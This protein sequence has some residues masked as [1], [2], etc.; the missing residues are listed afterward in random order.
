MY[1]IIIDTDVLTDIQHAVDWYN[2]QK[3]GLGEEFFFAFEKETQLLKQSPYIC[4]IKYDYIRCK[5]IR[6]Y[7]F[8]IHYSISEQFQTIIIAGVFHTSR[9]PKIWKQKN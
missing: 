5:L 8:L 2:E 4:A 9:N 3:T 1:R 6:K 7:P